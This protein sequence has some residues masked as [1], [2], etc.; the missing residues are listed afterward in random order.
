MSEWESWWSRAVLDHSADVFLS[1]L[2][3]LKRVLTRSFC[4]H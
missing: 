4:G 1:R 2:S 3:W